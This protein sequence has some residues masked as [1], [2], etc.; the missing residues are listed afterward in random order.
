M[1]AHSYVQ[2]LKLQQH[3]EP[4]SYI[5]GSDRDREMKIRKSISNTENVLLVSFLMYGK[6]TMHA[7][8][9]QSHFKMLLKTIEFDS[10]GRNILYRLPLSSS[11]AAAAA[12]SVCQTISKRWMHQVY[13]PRMKY[14]CIRNHRNTMLY[15]ECVHFDRIAA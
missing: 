11:S 7:Y 9:T 6:V 13:K 12:D 1:F 10:T 2:K 3:T 8:F 5:Y 4:K 15:T 14:I